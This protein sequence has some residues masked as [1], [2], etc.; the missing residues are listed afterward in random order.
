[1]WHNSSEDIDFAGLGEFI[2]SKRD[3]KRLAVQ[4]DG[5]TAAQ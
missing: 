3:L 2:R 5:L 1:M 4:F